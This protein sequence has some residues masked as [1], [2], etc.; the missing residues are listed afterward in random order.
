MD[1]DLVRMQEVDSDLFHMREVVDS[2][3]SLL[4]E[5]V[6][7]ETMAESVVM[8]MAK[9]MAMAEPVAEATKQEEEEGKLREEPLP[10]SEEL[11]FVHLPFAVGEPKHWIP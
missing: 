6:V 11:C 9:D 3:H 7:A 1:P 5:Q 8:G 4:K 10:P 2:D